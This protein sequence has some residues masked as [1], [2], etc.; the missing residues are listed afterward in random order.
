MSPDARRAPARLHA[1]QTAFAAHLRDPATAPAPAG[2]EERRLQ[3]YREL[4]YNNIDSLLAGNFPVI[5]ALRGDDAW[6][7]LVR[8][9][10]REHRSHTPLFPEIGREF[11][12]HLESRQQADAGDPPFLLELA[13]YEWVELALSL[14]DADL[15]AL[16]VDRDG[17][18]LDGVPLPSPLAWPLAYRWPVHRI[19]ATYQ[20]DTPPEHPTFL[21]VLRDRSDE[22]RFKQIDAL[23]YTLLQALHE[24]L[25]RE[26]AE[27]S[28]GRDLLQ[29]LAQQLGSDTEDMFLANGAALLRQ[30][31]ERDAIL[32]TVRA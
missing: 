32:G 25:Q 20:P 9:F 4:F 18:L 8:D 15:A 10:Y 26:P 3:I 17:D 16:D 27:R 12:R 11:L 19:A 29:R 2:I 6:H 22:V 7:A 24:N 31:H 28:N 14:D 13:H 5:R 1:Q 21:L 23:A 30:L